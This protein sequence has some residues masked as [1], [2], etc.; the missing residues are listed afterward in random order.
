MSPVAYL[1]LNVQGLHKQGCLAD[2]QSLISYL[3]FEET[4]RDD[5]QLKMWAVEATE[6]CME[7]RSF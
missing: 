6:R 2:E 3:N 7:E 4:D 1:L 5:N